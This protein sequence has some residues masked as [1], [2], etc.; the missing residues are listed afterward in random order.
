LTV[1]KK[2]VNTGGGTLTLSGVTL[3]VNG[4]TVTTGTVNV[5]P[6]GTYQVSEVPIAGYTGSFSGDCN[7]AGIVSV[8][9]GSNKVCTIT[10]TFIQPLPTL[11]VDKKIIN[12][13]GGTLTLS[14]VTLFINGS[15][16]TNGTANV[17]PSGVYQIFESPIPGYTGTFSGDCNSAGIVTLSP[18]NNKVCVLTNNDNPIPPPPPKNGTLTVIK[19]IINTGGGTLTLNSV[20]LEINGSVVVNGTRNVLPVANYIV[21][22]IPVP[23][24]ISSFTGDCNSSG[25]VTLAQYDNKTCNI[26]NTFIPPSTI[27]ITKVNN[28]SPRWGLDVLTAQGMVSGTILPGSTVSISW[29]DGTITP[30][31]PIIHNAWGPVAYEYHLASVLS[32]PNQVIASI[33]GSSNNVIS[34]SSPV[35]VNVK[36]H[37]TALSLQTS[38]NV[39]WSTAT[40][41][42]AKLV[43]TDSKNMPVSGELINLSGTGAINVH[44]TGT[45]STGQDTE[46]GI[47][48]N[49]VASGWT[50]QA[51]F[52]GDSFYLGSTSTVHSYSTLKHNIQLTMTLQP[53]SVLRGGLFSV[54]GTLTDITLN[55][56]LGSQAI[57]FTTINPMHIP[58][59]TTDV[60]GKYNESG[61]IAPS[62]A[63]NYPMQAK[64]SGTTL[65]NLGPSAKLTLKVS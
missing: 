61:L 24:Y 56:V 60:N 64:F 43:D 53:T 27:T 41:F 35:S 26:T 59:T 36:A 25:L 51:N 16:V 17:E 11:T 62:V 52:A 32:N 39:P 40:Q 37:H 18:G 30:G 22:E 45:N 55:K 42:I 15:R 58:N 8:T 3:M 46:F 63:G 19:K 34:T 38:R 47:A 21:S 13:N 9:T 31:I 57:S 49:T 23:N 54:N 44:D 1:D 48:P 10:N 20:T 50:Y 6:E 2:I 14:G 7:S 12:D 33:V 29:G 5:A 65:Y 28:T 4:T